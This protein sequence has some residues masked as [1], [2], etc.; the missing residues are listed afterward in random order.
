[1]RWMTWSRRTERQSGCLLS[2]TQPGVGC[3]VGCGSGG[4]LGFQQGNQ[5]RRGWYRRHSG[6]SA[7]RVLARHLGGFC[8]AAP[9][10]RLPGFLCR[11]C[12]SQPRIEGRCSMQ[13]QQVGS[14]FLGAACHCDRVEGQ[15]QSY[16]RRTEFRL[17]RW[18]CLQYFLQWVHKQI[19]QSYCFSSRRFRCK[20]ARIAWRRK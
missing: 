5:R 12:F 13:M 14:S 18:I 8:G 9:P 6:R 10:V 11:G 2:R 16:C 17:H 20:C 19:S 15:S 4:T 7:R 1:M 3:G